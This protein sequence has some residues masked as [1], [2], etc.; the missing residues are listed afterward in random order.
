M[1]FIMKMIPSGLKCRIKTFFKTI[2]T[3]KGEGYNSFGICFDLLYCLIRFRVSCD[4]YLKYRF[5]ELS[6]RYRK[7]FVLIYHQRHK[8]IKIT[9]RRFTYSKFG[10]YKK[11]PDLFL[12]EIICIPECGEEIFLEFARYHKK[13][14]IKPDRGSLGKG[15]EVFEYTDDEHAKELYKKS[16]EGQIIC[17]EYI[18]QHRAL[19]DLNPFSV[20]TIRVVT[21]LCDGEV[22]ILSAALKSGVGSDS[23]ADNMHKG[24]IGAQIDIATGIVSTFGYDYKYNRYTH[25]P[26]SNLKIIGFEVPNWNKVVERVTEAHK[27][28]PQCSIF[29]WDV[30]ITQDDVDIVEANN[31]PG[32]MLMQTMDRVPKGR[33][34]FK[35]FKKGNPNKIEIAVPKAKKKKK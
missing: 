15:I 10:F 26:I 6:N 34:L 35:L 12:R 2:E 30:A 31:A 29:G 17:E 24:G 8:Y 28:L 22:K 33:E 4:E 19:K 23:I 5:Y 11:I 21:L 14:I 20:N 25:H 18:S 27:R 7:Y 16:F 13:F 32:P 9:T 1:I 3:V